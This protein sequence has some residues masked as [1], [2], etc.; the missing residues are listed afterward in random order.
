MKQLFK[1]STQYKLI[2]ISSL[3]LVNTPLFAEMDHESMNMQGGSPPDDARDPHAYANGYTHTTGPYAL[4]NKRQLKLADEKVFQAFM[5]DRLEYD[6]DNK[7][8]I[9]DLQGWIGTTYDRFVIKAEGDIKDTRVEESQTDLLWSHA[10]ATL[11]KSPFWDAQV[12]V[13]F[14]TYETGENRQWLAF[15]LQ[16]LAP[17]W[18]EVDATA[19]LGDEGRTA[20]AVELEYELLL[21]Q[22]LILQPRAE[23]AF[24]GKDDQANGIGSG[25]STGSLGVRL[26]YEFTRQ[27]APYIGIERNNTF[28]DTADIA[29][30][31]GEAQ[32]FTS[33]VAGVK[34]W[35]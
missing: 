5:A 27:F 29:A 6:V 3:L 18:F 10:T 28:G 2:F 15:G 8:G 35:F 21:S 24:Y 22:R 30:A 31:S 14:D 32:D 12:G 19:Y 23:F 34:F 9:Y 4:P 17:Y 16:G 26:R 33:Y 7:T 20:L 13:S 1:L 11:F 25:L